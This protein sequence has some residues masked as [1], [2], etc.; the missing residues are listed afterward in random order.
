MN[1][2]SVNTGFHV[3]QIQTEGLA[4]EAQWKMA[5]NPVGDEMKRR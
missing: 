5:G 4:I 3:G 1:P 2:A